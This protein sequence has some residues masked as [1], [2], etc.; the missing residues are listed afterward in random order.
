MILIQIL[1]L[2][3]RCVIVLIIKTVNSMASEF[4]VLRK[5]IFC[6]LEEDETD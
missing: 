6:Q 4:V 5:K 2:K 1:G 3:K